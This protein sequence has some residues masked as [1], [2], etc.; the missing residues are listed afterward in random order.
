MEKYINTNKANKGEKASSRDVTVYTGYCSKLRVT[1]RRKPQTRL[2]SHKNSISS[3][4]LLFITGPCYHL[5]TNT[6]IQR[7]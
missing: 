7:E 3:I 6:K 5:Q 1:V 4:N 2:C